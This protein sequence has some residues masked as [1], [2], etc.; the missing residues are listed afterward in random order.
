MDGSSKGSSS[1]ISAYDN[2]SCDKYSFYKTLNESQKYYE[3]NCDNYDQ[4]N[5]FSE[6]ETFSNYITCDTLKTKKR[7]DCGSVIE[8]N[9]DTETIF[10]EP[11]DSSRWENL[12]PNACNYYEDSEE[13]GGA[14]LV[15]PPTNSENLFDCSNAVI[16]NMKKKICPEGSDMPPCKIIVE[17]QKKMSI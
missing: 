6:N 17:E 9:E 10:S 15:G 16:K 14:H 4:R 5:K 2:L 8:D 11:W 12:L 1:R 13:S 3:I 7:L